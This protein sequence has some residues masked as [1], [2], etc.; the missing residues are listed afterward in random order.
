M[1]RHGRLPRWKPRGSPKGYP[2][3]FACTLCKHRLEPLP[4]E[5]QAGAVSKAYE[6]LACRM[7]FVLFEDGRWDYLV[8]WLDA[9][10]LPRVGAY[11]PHLAPPAA[12]PKPLRRAKP[13]EDAEAMAK[14]RPPRMPCTA[15][16]SLTVADLVRSGV[17]SRPGETTHHDIEITMPPGAFGASAAVVRATNH[18]GAAVLDLDSDQIVATSRRGAKPGT[19]WWTLECPGCGKGCRKLYRPIL[20]GLDRWRCHRC[21]RVRFPSQM[22]KRRTPSPSSLM[23]GI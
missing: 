8:W 20:P 1:S 22:P 19:T 10:G 9:D 2:E 13:A 21:A 17:F 11:P 12:K 5:Y 16:K 6:C 3:T 15:C 7:I 23:K 18:A 4:P 14:K